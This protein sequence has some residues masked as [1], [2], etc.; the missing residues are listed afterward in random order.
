MSPQGGGE[1]FI[2]LLPDTDMEEGKKVA[3]RIRSEVAQSPFRL[4][5]GEESSLTISCGMGNWKAHRE[6]DELIRIMGDR[7][8]RAK[9]SGRNQVIWKD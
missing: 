7:L 6:L 5:N 1:E 9:Q 2:F 8:Y 3:E 4:E